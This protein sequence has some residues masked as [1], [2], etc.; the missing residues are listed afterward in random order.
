MKKTRPIKLFGMS[1][2]FFTAFALMVGC[3]LIK[4][5]QDIDKGQDRTVIIGHV[6][7]SFPGDGPIIVAACSKTKPAEI[8]MHT[9]LHDSGEYEILVDQGKYYVFAYWDKNSNLT[10]DA[11]EPAGQ[12]GSPKWVK[13]TSVGVVFDIN[14]HIPE[15]GRRIE[16]PHGTV[17]ASA[18][19]QNLY[20][21]QAGVITDL[22]DERFSEANGV[23]GFWEPAAFFNQFGG[24]IYFLEQYDPQKI[25]VLFIHG[26][27][28]TPKGWQYF[29]DHMDRTRFQP[30][31]FY[32]ATGNRIDSMAYLLLW[33]LMNLQAK[34]QFDE[35]YITAHSMGGLVARSFI[36]NYGSQF[37]YVKLLVS[38][39]TP[40]GGDRM[41]ELG[42]KQSPIVIPS[43][44]DMQPEG[45]F[46]QSLYRKKL[47]ES[48]D[49][50]MFYGYRGSRNPFR[51]NNDGTITLS[52]LLDDRP[53]SEA[54]MNYAFDEDHDSIL[55]SKRV[56]E[57]YNAVLT[58]F[59]EKQGEPQQQ[60][61]GYLKVGFADDYDFKGAKPS[62]VLILRPDNKKNGNTIMYLNDD[63]N[64]KTLGPFPPGNYT[65]SLVTMAAK[66]R[67]TYVPVSIQR[68]QTKTINFEFVPDGVINGCVTT[69]LKPEDKFPGRPDYRYR[70]ID[71]TIHIQSIA[72]KGDSVHR[73]L[74]PTEGPEP[75]DLDYF[76]SRDDGCHNQCF[77]FFGLPA[78]DYTLSIEAK[79]YRSVEKKYSVTP[80]MPQYYRPTELV[81]E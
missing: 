12:Y 37:P 57:Q 76:I 78:G 66:T 67:R 59:D 45:D 44:I 64:G 33:K 69:G 77:V 9:V 4:A 46:I 22:D 63:D 81:P 35:M 40:W 62:R 5:K 52:S 55:T 7:G 15:G 20:S 1:I 16:I 70:T 68:N 17:V 32:Y 43:W 50:Y 18:D 34:Y 19:P 72:L 3:A 21:R 26:A 51:S 8:N 29:V 54:N 38:L 53:Q 23:K 47:P 28:G 11:G 14:I 61:G 80:G 42:T 48:V 71:T 2:A 58:A 41:A 39:A 79:D 31:F 24:S 75:D 36:V 6:Y 65:A 60:S 73:V 27:T 30:W 56:I 10:Y 25:P 74:Q 13:T 49:F